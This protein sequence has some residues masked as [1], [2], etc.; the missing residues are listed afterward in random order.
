MSDP[1]PA[2]AIPGQIKIPYRWSAGRVGSAFLAALRDRAVILGSRCP[3]CRQVSVPPRAH[4][5][6]CAVVC[7]ETVETGPRGTLTAWTVVRESLPGIDV[8][9]V[10]FAFG[11]I[12]LDGA[13]IALVHLLGEIEPGAIRAGLR[14]EP[15]FAEAR[16]GHILDLR[17][18]RP[19][20]E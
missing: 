11:A 4:C 13:D 16:R 8:M 1:I 10:P 17:Y 14:F 19:V 2:I 3:Q 15:V 20:P 5:P 7:T 6:A 18:F 9:P 12:R